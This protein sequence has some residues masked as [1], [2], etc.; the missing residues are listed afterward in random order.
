LSD[1]DTELDTSTPTSPVSADSTLCLVLSEAAWLG[2]ESAKSMKLCSSIQGKQLVILLD[3]GSSHSFLDVALANQLQ[4]LS[5][6]PKPLLVRVANGVV[7]SCRHQLLQA[8]WQLQGLEFYSN[9]KV[10]PL[11]ILT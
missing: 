2:V 10:L 6:L 3:S 8:Q 11:S 5:L 7:L 1:E 4:G 9:F